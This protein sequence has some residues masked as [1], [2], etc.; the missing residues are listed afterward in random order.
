MLLQIKDRPGAVELEDSEAGYGIQLE[1][2]RFGYRPDLPILQVTHL[3]SEPL[4]M[5]S[6]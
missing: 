2:V 4:F 5:M 3:T 1:D 6:L